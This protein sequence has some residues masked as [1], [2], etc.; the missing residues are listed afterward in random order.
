MNQNPLFHNIEKKTGVKMND[1]MRLAN[2]FQHANFKDE[3]T[4][5]R[6]IKQV[7]RLANK[8]VRKETE[9]QIV[10]AIINGS[11]SM[12]FNTIARMLDKK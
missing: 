1:V 10:H 5:R 12:D 8:P 9:D 4:V 2:S 11:Q 6:L 7:G 3:A